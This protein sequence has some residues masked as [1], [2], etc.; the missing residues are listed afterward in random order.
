MRPL[1]FADVNNVYTYLSPDIQYFHDRYLVYGIIAIILG[2]LIVIGLPLLLLLEPFLN[3]KMNFVKI[4]PL[5]DQFQRCYKDNYRCF[6]AH[7][8]ICRLIIITIIIANIPEEFISRYLLNTATTIT[9]LIHLVVRPYSDNI[10][11]ISDGAILHLMVLVSVLPLFE[12]FDTF[13]SSFAVGIAFV[14][15]ILPLVQF[16]VMMIFISKPRMKEII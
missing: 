13:D 15:V 9:A 10:L 12:Y 5:L 11:N 7:Y 8:M 2:L 4:K 14:L 6:A 3:S 1:T 16:V